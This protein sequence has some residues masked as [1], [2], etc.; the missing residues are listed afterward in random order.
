CTRSTGSWNTST[1]PRFAQ[2]FT[3]RRKMIT[4]CLRLF[5]ESSI[6]IRSASRARASLRNKRKSPRWPPNN[7]PPVFRREH[8]HH[9]EIHF[10]QNG[11]ESR[12]SQTGAAVSGSHGTRRH[13]AGPDCRS[14]QTAYRLLLHPARRHHGQHVAWSVDG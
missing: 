5:W 1:C 11:T 9:Q 14:A 12:R 13:C 3:G 2:L 6:P 8:V 7:S 4:S 10:P